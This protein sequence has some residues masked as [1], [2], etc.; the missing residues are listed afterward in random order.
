[1][2]IARPSALDPHVRLLVSCC[3]LRVVSW[4]TPRIVPPSALDRLSCVLCRAVFSAVSARLHR[5]T[6]RA[7][8]LWDVLCPAVFGALLASCAT[9]YLM[10]TLLLLSWPHCASLGFLVPRASCLVFP[11]PRVTKVDEAGREVCAGVDRVRERL[12][13]ARGDR[14]GCQRL[15]HGGAL[16]PGCPPPSSVHR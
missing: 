10:V 9:D 12:C 4:I 13:S 1:M 15:S 16:V 6:E 2:V 8:P 14:P 7:R 3:V 11:S 5:T